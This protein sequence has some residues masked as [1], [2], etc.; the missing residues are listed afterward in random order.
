MNIANVVKMIHL[1]LD[2]QQRKSALKWVGNGK[3]MLI[4][5]M[6]QKA[7]REYTPVL[8]SLTALRHVYGLPRF[9]SNQVIFKTQTSI[10][11]EEFEDGVS[12]LE[13]ECYKWGQDAVNIHVQKVSKRRGLSGDFFVPH[14]VASMKFDGDEYQVICDNSPVLDSVDCRFMDEAKIGV[15]TIPV[16]SESIEVLAADYLAA[17]LINARVEPELVFDLAWLSSQ[18]EVMDLELLE[19]AVN[20]RGVDM[21]QQRIINLVN[22]TQTDY[23]LRNFGS[24]EVIGEPS[25]MNYQTETIAHQ[26]CLKLVESLVTDS[27]DQFGDEFDAKR[28][29]EFGVEPVVGTDR[30]VLNAGMQA[31]Q[32]IRAANAVR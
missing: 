25:I 3:Q 31:A 8:S 15:G 1:G 30:E 13:D 4:A 6:A 10:T 26:N 7:F 28:K 11:K 29:A 18:V 2:E 24:I 9:T 27:M 22:L 16:Q 21:V 5:L 23:I 14:H 12:L 17:S 19:S 20:N 32:A